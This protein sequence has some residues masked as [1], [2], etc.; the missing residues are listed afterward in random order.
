MDTQ[1]NRCFV[2]LFAQY[3]HQVYA[4]IASLLANW[5]DADE[6]MQETSIALWEMFDNFQEGTNF[7]SWACRIAHYRVLRFREKQRRD[8]LQFNAKFLEQVAAAVLEEAEFFDVRRNALEECVAQLQT[9][10][11]ELLSA[12]YAQGR[13]VKAVAEQLARPAKGVYKALARLRQILFT[14]V[15]RKLALQEMGS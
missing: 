8:R 1:R 9:R 4:Y 6:V 2:Q 15:K 12:C 14:C 11:K 10:E 3:Q 5:T 7:C 13:T